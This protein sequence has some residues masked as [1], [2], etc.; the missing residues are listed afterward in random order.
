MLAGLHHRSILS[1]TPNDH[2]IKALQ[3]LRNRNNIEKEKM[4][5]STRA[6]H[7]SEEALKAA[8]TSSMRSII[9]AASTADFIA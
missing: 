2:D 1:E 8:I 4:R 3:F 5:I 6:Y 9:D 7:L